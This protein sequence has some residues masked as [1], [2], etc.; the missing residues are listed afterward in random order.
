MTYRI[1]SGEEALAKWRSVTRPPTPDDLPMRR[2][3]TYIRTKADVLEWLA[4]IEASRVA[5]AEQS[6]ELPDPN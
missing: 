3:H 2:D 5:E 4:E 1:L 6:E